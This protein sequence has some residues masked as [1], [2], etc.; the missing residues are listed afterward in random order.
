MLGE[1][2]ADVNIAMI[3]RRPDQL[4]DLRLVGVADDPL[5][6][7]QCGQLVRRTLRITARNQDARRRI[8]AVYAANRVP[9]VFIGGG[10]DRARV[11]NHEIRVCALRRG[12]QAL[13]GQQRFQ[14]CAVGLRGAATEVLNEELP[15]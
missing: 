12:L 6:A 9:D 11:E 8:L 15:H 2:I 13:G 3:G 4:R 1:D 14:S 10:R 7:R 5:D